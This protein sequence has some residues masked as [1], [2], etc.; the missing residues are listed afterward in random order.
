MKPLP[1]FS[2][3]PRPT[4]SRKKYCLYILWACV[5]QTPSVTE[6]RFSLVTTIHISNIEVVNATRFQFGSYKTQQEKKNQT[7]SNH[8]G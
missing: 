3:L 6:N 5:F 7:T 8:F 4:R 1:L 2:P